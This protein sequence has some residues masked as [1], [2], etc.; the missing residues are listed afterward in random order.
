MTL[1]AHIA[2]EQL[3]IC[4]PMVSTRSWTPASIIEEAT[5]AVDPDT[6]PAVCTRK[7]GLP[8]APSASARRFA[9]ASQLPL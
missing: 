1:S 7:T 6:E 9:N 8:T 2:S 5:I 3:C 4:Q